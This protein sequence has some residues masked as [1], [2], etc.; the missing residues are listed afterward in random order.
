MQMFRQAVECAVQ[1]DRLGLCVTQFDAK[2]LERGLVCSPGALPTA[3]ALVVSVERI[4]Y[5]KQV[6]PFLFDFLLDAKTDATKTSKYLWLYYISLVVC[7]S[8]VTI[9]LLFK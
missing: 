5:F 1:G 4:V 9:S 8:F 3:H 2:L 6:S 7:K